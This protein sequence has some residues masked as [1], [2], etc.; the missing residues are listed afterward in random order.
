M[1]DKR[2][3][4]RAFGGDGNFEK[5]MTAKI[6][7]FSLISNSFQREM[8]KKGSQTYWHSMHSLQIIE[9][10]GNVCHG[11]KPW[12]TLNFNL[13]SYFRDDMIYR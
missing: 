6:V 3:G 10:N 2:I 4:E 12:H 5:I 1:F 8:E 11:S 7:V 13:C 9:K